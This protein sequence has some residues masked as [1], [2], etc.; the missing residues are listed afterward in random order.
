MIFLH[1]SVK[2]LEENLHIDLAVHVLEQ[3]FRLL[4]G[5]G[6]LLSFC[7][8]PCPAGHGTFLGVPSL[9]SPPMLAWASLFAFLLLLLSFL[10]PFGL[11]SML[12]LSTLELGLDPRAWC[13]H[14]LVFSPGC[15]PGT[16]VQSMVRNLE[17]QL[18]APAKKPA[19]GVSL[20]SVPSAG[21]QRAAVPGGKPQ[22]GCRT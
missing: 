13:I 9:F 20:F 17:K 5:K 10:F 22:V 15:L 16:L 14:T 21:P 4:R 11:F 1:F 6:S 7:A 3:R 2:M 19:G 8:Q 18:E 12:P